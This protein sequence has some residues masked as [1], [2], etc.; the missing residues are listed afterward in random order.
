M[1]KNKKVLFVVAMA[2]PLIIVLFLLGRNQLL[3][4]TIV[5]GSLLI[6]S[7]VTSSIMIIKAHKNQALLDKK[8]YTNVAGAA[9][10]LMLYSFVMLCIWMFFESKN[11]IFQA[12]LVSYPFIKGF[13]TF[14]KN[15]F[16]N[17]MQVFVYYRKFEEEKQKELEDKSKK[18]AEVRKKMKEKKPS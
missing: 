17:F 5:L 2:I 10:D 18:K 7:L 4:P 3:N 8:Y 1:S 13:D 16:K 12:I 14:L 11:A 6:V 15:K 9:I